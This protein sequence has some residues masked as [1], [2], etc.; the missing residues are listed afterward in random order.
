[1]SEESPNMSRQSNWDAYL[2]AQLYEQF[3]FGD[4]DLEVE[5]RRLQRVEFAQIFRY[6]FREASGD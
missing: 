1:V 2:L 5:L 3:R 4:S 6:T